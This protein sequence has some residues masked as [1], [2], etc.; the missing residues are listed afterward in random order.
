VVA[1]IGEDS[2]GVLLPDCSGDEVAVCCKTLRSAVNG[3]NIARGR[4]LLSLSIGSA[5]TDALSGLPQTLFSLAHDS[6]FR[7]KLLSIRSVRS[8]TALTVKRLLEARD[9]NTGQHSD[10]SQDLI[11]QLAVNI[12]L[13]D[14]SIDNLKLLGRFHDIG[15]IGVP[16]SI[17]LK[18]DRLTPEEFQTMTSHCEIGYFIAMSLPDVAHIADWIL[19]HHERWDGKGYPLKLQGDQIPIECRAM[20]IVDAYDAIVSDRPYR[21]ALPQE[22][23]IAELQRCSG[24]Q[25]DPHLTHEF[26]KLLHSSPPQAPVHRDD[27]LTSIADWASQKQLEKIFGRPGRPK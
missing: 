13:P 5:H 21:K 14:S 15:K 8:A 24:T 18:P 26:I 25:F 19:K 11:A 12:R 4:D 16:D 1:R 20:A 27:N 7:Q 6:I 3:F 17:L 23:A 2:F 9:F 10:R 22:Q